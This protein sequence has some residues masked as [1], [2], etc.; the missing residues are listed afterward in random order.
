MKNGW[1]G[2]VVFGHLRDSAELG[3]RPIGIKALGTHPGKSEKG[4][5][6]TVIDRTVHFA[7][8]AFE[9]G[10]WLYADGDGIVVAE[11]AIHG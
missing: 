10:A 6:S 5:H 11:Q 8:I 9:P 3:R 4:L 1:A 7:G 2:I